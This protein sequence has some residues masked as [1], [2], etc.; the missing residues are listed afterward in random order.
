MLTVVDLHQEEEL[1]SERMSQVAGG[2]DNNP[3]V[4]ASTPNLFLACCNGKHFD[5][6]TITVR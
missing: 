5:T 1:S 4:A 2:T 3:V 6:A